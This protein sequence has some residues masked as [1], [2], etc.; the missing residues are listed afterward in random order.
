M[1]SP[2]NSTKRLSSIFTLGQARDDSALFPAA[3]SSVPLREI[4]ERNGP[5]STLVQAPSSPEP[6]MDQPSIQSSQHASTTSYTSSPTLLPLTK[7]GRARS[8]SVAGQLSRPG[9][10]EGSRSRPT[11]PNTFAPFGSIGSATSRSSTPNSAKTSKRRSWL[12][13]KAE[14]PSTEQT[15]PEAQAW[16]AG[17]RDHVPYNLLPLMQGEKAS[18]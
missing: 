6:S 18:D 3:P 5:A 17:L 10:G 14:K 16:G 7:D 9:S 4:Q 13:G 15:R 1:A 11:T 2:K 12:S 8:R